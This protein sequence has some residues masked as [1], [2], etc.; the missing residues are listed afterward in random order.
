MAW[1]W[2]WRTVATLHSIS[3]LV[4]NEEKERLQY[5][6]LSARARQWPYAVK[7]A[8]PVDTDSFASQIAA[9]EPPHLIPPALCFGYANVKSVSPMAAVKL[10]D[11]SYGNSLMVRQVLH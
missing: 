2:G 10:S 11:L 5:K 3:D 9:L 8:H 7:T 6:K 1:V 4:S